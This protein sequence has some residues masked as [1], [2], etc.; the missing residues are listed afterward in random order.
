M[1]LLTEHGILGS[2]RT[3]PAPTGA[4]DGLVPVAAHS[5]VLISR[6]RVVARCVAPVAKVRPA[7]QVINRIKWDAASYDA[8][9]FDVLIVPELGGTR[10][11]VRGGS[12]TGRAIILGAGAGTE[13]LT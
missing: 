1:E 13:M 10:A 6:A 8:A 7:A 11:C 2:R 4:S 12:R 9:E 3:D 5:T